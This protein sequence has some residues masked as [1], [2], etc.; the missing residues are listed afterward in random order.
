LPEEHWLTHIEKSFQEVN[1]FFHF[2]AVT[3]LDSGKGG[4]ATI[5]VDDK[6]IAELKANMRQRLDR[7][8]IAR[9]ILH[10]SAATARQ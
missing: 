3:R 9:L 2:R 10:S 7:I 5:S 6:P 4:K 8:S 1:R